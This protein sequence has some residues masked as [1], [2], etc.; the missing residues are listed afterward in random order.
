MHHKDYCLHLQNAHSSPIHSA[1][2]C[3]IWPTDSKHMRDERRSSALAPGKKNGFL[4]VCFVG[5]LVGCL[6]GG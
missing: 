2:K 4:F 1:T 5:W 6:R 3:L